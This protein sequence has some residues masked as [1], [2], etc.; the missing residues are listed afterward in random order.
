MLTVMPASSSA[1]SATLPVSPAA[2]TSTRKTWLSVPPETMRKPRAA[3][4]AA[5]RFA[6]RT[7]RR[8]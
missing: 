6:L 5:S 7:M 3:R 1:V 8:W 4:A 2:A